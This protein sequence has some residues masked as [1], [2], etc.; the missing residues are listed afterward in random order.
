MTP[1]TR[2]MKATVIL[3]CY[4]GEETIAEQMDALA[5]QNWQ[6]DWE[7]IMADNA[8]TDRSVEIVQSYADRIPNMRIL[9][10]YPGSGPRRPVAV[11]Y[12]RA[13]EAAKSDIFITCEADDV[14]GEGWLETMVAA[15]QTEHY[16]GSALDDQKLN[17]R[18]LIK[19]NEGMQTAETG[20]PTF[21]GPLR[22]P[23]SIGCTVGISRHLWNT[24]GDPD[25]DLPI[26]WDTDYSWRAQLAGFKLTFVP[27][28]VMHYRQRTTFKSRYKQGHNYGVSAAKLT[29]KYGIDSHFRFL[30]Y[31]LFHLVIAS[32]LLATSFLPNTRTPRHRIWR[33]ACAIGQLKGFKYVLSGRR[34]R[35]QVPAELLHLSSR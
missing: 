21:V 5:Q 6:D 28:A 13:F 16:I 30:A 19:P 32:F 11:S 29:A 10:V 4:N 12:L 31:N 35:M 25:A 1:E 9:N 17:D 18:D 14:A 3:P 34:P 22:L 27:E 26:H 15:M 8:S 7:F 24:I 2:S 23:F 33:V 20:F